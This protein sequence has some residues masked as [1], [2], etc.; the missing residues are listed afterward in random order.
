MSSHRLIWMLS[1][2]PFLFP[3]NPLSLYAQAVLS[4]TIMHCILFGRGYC[5]LDAWSTLDCKC[6][7]FGAVLNW[8]EDKRHT[9]LVA[10]LSFRRSL[11][12]WRNDSQ[13]RHSLPF[14]FSLYIFFFTLYLSQSFSLILFSLFLFLTISVP[15]CCL[16]TPACLRHLAVSLVFLS[17]SL[18]LEDTRCKQSSSQRHTLHTISLAF[19]GVEYSQLCWKL[20]SLKP[21]FPLQQFIVGEFSVFGEQLGL[22]RGWCQRAPI[23]PC[24]YCSV[25]STPPPFNLPFFSWH[26]FCDRKRGEPGM[27]VSHVFFFF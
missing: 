25:P 12:G 1:Q 24:S 18:L 21:P 4:I 19:K 3:I 20:N 16:P 8:I 9:P 5:V 2:G 23:V 7:F 13:R 6:V 10:A 15:L 14:S 26:S 22:S 17:L 11:W 27:C